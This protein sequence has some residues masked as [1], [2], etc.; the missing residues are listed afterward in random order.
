ML[1]DGLFL[2]A[3]R[4]LHAHARHVSRRYLLDDGL[5]LDALRAHARHVSRRYFLYADLLLDVLHAH[6]YAHR[7]LLRYQLDDDLFLLSFC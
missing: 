3:L 5:F 4:A 2:D 6:A 1:D 7:A